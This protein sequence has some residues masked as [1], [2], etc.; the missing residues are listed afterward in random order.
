[1]ETFASI[2][3]TLRGIQNGLVTAFSGEEY[4]VYCSC[5]IARESSALY[6]ALF[7]LFSSPFT[8][9][10]SL[11]LFLPFISIFSLSFPLSFPNSLLFRYLVLIESGTFQSSSIIGVFVLNIKQVADL[12]FYMFLVMKAFEYAILFV[13]DGIEYFR[14]GL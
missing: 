1:M 14:R 2:L 3:D 10:L 7:S 13:H 8:T 6:P 4:V 5:P 9:S 12:R 11:S